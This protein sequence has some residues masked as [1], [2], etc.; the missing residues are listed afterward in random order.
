M[1]HMYIGEDVTFWPTFVQPGQTPPP[2]CLFVCFRNSARLTISNFNVWVSGFAEVLSLGTSVLWILEWVFKGWPSKL[3]LQVFEM[4][5]FNFIKRSRVFGGDVFQQWLRDVYESYQF[6]G[7]DM[8]KPFTDG[9]DFL[10][11]LGENLGSGRGRMKKI[12]S[13]WSQASGKLT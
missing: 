10:I 6:L 4:M 13:T 8:F 9:N 3:T 11:I 7:A 2:S 5:G 1:H 12:P